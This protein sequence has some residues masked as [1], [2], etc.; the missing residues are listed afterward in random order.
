MVGYTGSKTTHTHRGNDLT[1]APLLVSAW[2]K[3]KITGVEVDNKDLKD[4]STLA[5]GEV[6]YVVEADH[7]M[8]TVTLQD[9][10]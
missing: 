4:Y 3:N 7:A 10:H 6:E 2:V 8:V 5:P 1:F 9:T